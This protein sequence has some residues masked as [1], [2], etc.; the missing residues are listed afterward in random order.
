M[1]GKDS[2]FE[3]GPLTDGHEVGLPLPPELWISARWEE[4]EDDVQRR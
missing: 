1:L 4:G 3:D 2:S